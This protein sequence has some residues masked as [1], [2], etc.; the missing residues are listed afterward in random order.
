M[1][2]YNFEIDFINIPKF[3]IFQSGY[4][5]GKVKD[6]CFKNNIPVTYIFYLHCVFFTNVLLLESN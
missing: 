1:T 3:L 5:I 4:E 2:E 6:L